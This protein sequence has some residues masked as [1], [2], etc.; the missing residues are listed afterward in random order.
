MLIKIKENKGSSYFVL[1]ILVLAIF[2]CSGFVEWVKKDIYKYWVKKCEWGIQSGT[3]AAM[4]MLQNTAEN[5]SSVGNGFLEEN[6]KKESY[7]NNIKLEHLSS[8]EVFF[9]KY[10]EAV[11]NA[12]LKKEDM[13]LEDATLIAIVEL[14]NDLYNISMYKNKNLINVGSCNSLSEVET[15]IN[16]K[17]QKTEIFLYEDNEKGVFDLENRT[18]FIA[19]TENLKL[20]NLSDEKNINV[21]YFEG[22]NIE[23][24]INMR[25][26]N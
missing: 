25:G 7:N 24:L 14:Q 19:I 16:Q 26:D 22:S 9:E 23:R 4:I 18:Y 17:L 10:Y 13:L 12:K 21:F 1:I 11:K 6:I 3:K 5:I 20:P 8:I 2:L 15:Y